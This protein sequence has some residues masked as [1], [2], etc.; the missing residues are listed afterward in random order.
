M[1]TILA[2]YLTAIFS[3]EG[4]QELLLN[5]GIDEEHTIKVY[6]SVLIFLAIMTIWIYKDTLIIRPYWFVKGYIFHIR[7]FFTNIKNQISQKWKEK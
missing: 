4:I 2:L 7:G 6:F 5:I 1:G 3:Y